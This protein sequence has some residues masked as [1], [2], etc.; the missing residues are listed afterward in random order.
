M[1]TRCLSTVGAGILVI[2][3]EGITQVSRC[4]AI[5]VAV[6]LRLS[7]LV[8]LVSLFRCVENTAR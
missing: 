2:E 3:R 5:Q 8:S 7:S 6:K 1:W 4:R